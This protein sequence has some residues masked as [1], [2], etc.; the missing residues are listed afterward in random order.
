MKTSNDNPVLKEGLRQAYRSGTVSPYL[1]KRVIS[2]LET[3]IPWTVPW[4]K[5]AGGLICATVIFSFMSV[6][7]DSKPVISTTIASPISMSLHIPS[8]ERQA[9]SH[10][11]MKI[12]SLSSLRNVPKLNRVHTPVISIDIPGDF[13]TYK[14]KGEMLC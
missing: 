3:K 2:R 11:S 12:P 10:S 1:A 9:N 14:Q 7:N 5:M 6:Y 13:C 8:I 4:L